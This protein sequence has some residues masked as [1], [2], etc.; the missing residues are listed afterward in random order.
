MP[1]EVQDSD[2][3]FWKPPIK[4]SKDPDCHGCCSA[5]NISQ[6]MLKIVFLLVS[7]Y[8]L[9]NTNAQDCMFVVVRKSNFE[10]SLVVLLR[11]R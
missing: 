3:P 8:K 5:L 1:L 4:I 6:V 7:Y 2:L 9:L 11:V 10:S